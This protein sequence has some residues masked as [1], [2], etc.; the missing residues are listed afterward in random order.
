M[1]RVLIVD[2][3]T[4]IQAIVRAVLTRNGH[5]VLLA[6]S[7]ESAYSLIQQGGI[8]IVICDLHLPGISGLE[9]AQR[10]QN[11]GSR[12]LFVLMS[13]RLDGIHAD[14]LREA[15]INALLAKPFH[16]HEITDLLETLMGVRPPR[17]T[18]VGGSGSAR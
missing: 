13:G 7:A 1:L 11:E 16:A 10:L 5:H 17:Q 2:D 4:V 12:P 8:D 15:P 3:E 14:D 6:S 18:D 9:L